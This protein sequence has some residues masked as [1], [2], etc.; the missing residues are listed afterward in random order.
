MSDAE[1]AEERRNK[2]VEAR[3]TVEHTR[4]R[5]AAAKARGGVE[6]HV[7]LEDVDVLVRFASAAITA[8]MR[9]LE[10]ELR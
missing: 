6:L 4:E 8:Y 2:L 10:K 7:S 3:L 5:L 1:S 9:G